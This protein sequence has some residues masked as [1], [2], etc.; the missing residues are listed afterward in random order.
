M[1]IEVTDYDYKDQV[2]N[3]NKPQKKVL[4]QQVEKV[5]PQAVNQSTDTVPDIYHAAKVH[6]GWIE[7]A[8]DLKQG[9]R[10]K[11]I[12]DKETK[13]HEVAE[14]ESGR[15]R[16]A[17]APEGDKVFVYGREVKDFR[18]VDYDA[19][20][21]LNVSATQQIKR[22]KDAEIA[23]LKKRIAELEAK[24]RARDAKLAAIEKLLSS[25]STVMAQ[26]AKAATANGQE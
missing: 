19:I 16:T 25:S 3:G 11:L 15:F 26:P 1:Q 20:A 6:A 12:T 2:A 4:G 8:T 18:T 5:F 7:L 10:V 17:T 9:D 22:E 14:V 21:M 24:D 13:I 23:A